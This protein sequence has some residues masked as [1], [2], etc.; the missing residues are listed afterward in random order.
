MHAF[1]D[2]DDS[3]P[4]IELTIRGDKRKKPRKIIALLDTGHTG[5]LALPIL[6]LIEIGATLE[7]FGPVRLADGSEVSVYYFKVF[8]EIDGVER[9]VQASM[10][11]NQNINEAIAGLELLGSHIAVMDF[12]NKNLLV[13]THEQLD[14]LMK[15]G[16]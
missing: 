7:S 4:K 2:A 3:S 16:A 12:R 9:Q 10:I 1:F 8:V 15:K 13:T 11:D 14:K 5:S 6:D